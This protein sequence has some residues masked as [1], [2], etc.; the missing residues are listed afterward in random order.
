MICPICN[1]D[2]LHLVN[3]TNYHC[4]SCYSQITLEIYEFLKNQNEYIKHLEL[5]SAEIYTRMRCL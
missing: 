3:Q 4:N 1:K 2:A 5:K